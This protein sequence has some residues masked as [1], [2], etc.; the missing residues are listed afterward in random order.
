MRKVD[1]ILMD[2]KNKNIA[3]SLERRDKIVEISSDDESMPQSQK[4]VTHQKNL[5]PTSETKKHKHKHKT[6]GTHKGSTGKHTVRTITVPNPYL[7]SNGVSE[8]AVNWYNDELTTKSTN[9]DI[10]RKSGS[11]IEMDFVPYNEN[12][13][14]EFYDDPNEL[15]E[16][17]RLL[18]ASKAAGNSN[19]SQEINSII[20]E[21]REAGVIF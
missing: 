9:N 20:S 6:S 1:D 7:E 18:I 11:G 15:C 5:K 12:V 3:D 17:L 16:R 19:H 10:E 13:V 21:L 14:Y 2:V 8:K 4:K